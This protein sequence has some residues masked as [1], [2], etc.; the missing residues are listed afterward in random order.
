MAIVLQIFA[1][2][3]LFGYP[4]CSSQ[5]Q[6]KTNNESLL[7]NYKKQKESEKDKSKRLSNYKKN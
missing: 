6:T 5:N 1:V 2:V 3:I 4:G 7:D